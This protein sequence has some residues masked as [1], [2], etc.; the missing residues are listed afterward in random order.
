MEKVKTKYIP[1]EIEIIIFDSE[2]I[3]TLST[4]SGGHTPDIEDDPYE[5]SDW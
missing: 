2:D 3:M 1:P 5:D 4:P